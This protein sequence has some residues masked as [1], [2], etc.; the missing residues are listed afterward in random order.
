MP[1]PALSSAQRDAL[2]VLAAVEGDVGAHKRRSTMGDPGP[3]RVNAVA[4]HSLARAGLARPQL[5]R[6]ASAYTSAFDYR[7]TDAG[8]AALDA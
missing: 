3:P 2:R 5:R 1:T 6:Y 7:I 4:A 8:R